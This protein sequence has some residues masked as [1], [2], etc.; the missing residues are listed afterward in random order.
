MKILIVG[1][2]SIGQ[3]H[4]KILQ[5]YSNIQL[6][7]LRTKKGELKNEINIKEFFNL[8]DA[9]SFKPDGVIISNPTTYHV[10][11]ALPFLKKGCKVLIEKP[12]SSSDKEAQKLEP[13]KD[14]IRVAYCLRFH[15]LSDFVLDS[16]DLNTI[17]KVNNLHD[18]FTRSRILP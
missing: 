14:K 6:A 1:L 8:N 18:H 13:Y 4:F 10:E 3:R 11:S 2:G 5:S 12:I 9:L 15:P 17:Y 7:A 16:I